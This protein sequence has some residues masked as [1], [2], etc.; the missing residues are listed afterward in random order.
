MR[1]ALAQINSTV[2]AIESH[3]DTVIKWSIEARDKQRADVIVFPELTLTGYPPDDLLLR[4][5]LHTRIQT[6]LTR[7]ASSVKGIDIIIGYPDKQN[8]GMFNAAA[9]IRDGRIE[10]RHYKHH[11]PNYD[12]FDE[13]R[14][15][16]PG[17]VPPHWV[18]IKGTKIGVC[19]CEDLWHLD[20]C[21]Q[22]AKAGCSVLF[23]LNASPFDTKKQA[24]RRALLKKRA[25]DNQL[26]I[27]YVNQVGGQ[28]ELVF[29]GNSSVTNPDGSLRLQAPSF[30]EALI[31]VDCT[32]P[33]TNTT[34][35]TQDETSLAYQALVLGLGDYVNKN[36]FRSVLM[37][38]SGGIDSA[39]TLAIA[40][41]ALGHQR[42]STYMLPSRYTSNMSIDL[43]AT[44]AKGLGVK[45]SCLSIEPAFKTLLTSLYTVLGD[46][47]SGTVEENIQAR[48]RGLLLMAISN[49]NQ[50]LLLSSSN[51]S[52]LA[53]G[54]CTLY[55]DAI[56][57]FNA[58]KDVFKTQVYQLARY[59]N[60][61]QHIIPEAIIERE[62]TAE[63][64]ANQ[65]D[66]DSLPPYD[67]LDAILTR[68]IEQTQSAET[69]IKA[70]FDKTLVNN[71]IQRV[72]NNEYK[73]Y[74]ATIGTRISIKAF[75]RGRRYPVTYK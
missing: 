56:G 70:G 29:D 8:E 66:K 3:T 28:D 75:G 6:A 55:G 41:D 2:G 35:L 27:V 18:N 23:C 48:C 44:M 65:Q 19:I 58:L 38:L 46:D 24:E 72:I 16:T 12:V 61:S 11:L 53:V 22:A 45:H 52:E 33:K 20:F 49:K 13:K 25:T 34:V 1:V 50:A 73:R 10:S 51:K 31:T 62:P 4:P 5:S 39:L 15:F 67:V 9:L 59:C 7:I 57:G 69:I 32:F 63:L 71:I 42:V 74:Q 47:L 21:A 26:T 68:Y 36:G 40:V 43:A 37:G 64:A 60:R 54:Y 17:I 30:K 14:H